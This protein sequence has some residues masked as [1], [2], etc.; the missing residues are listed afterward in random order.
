VDT[1]TQ[2]SG[3]PGLDRFYQVLRK[4]VEADERIFTVN[5]RRIRSNPHWLRDHIHEMKGY[6]Y[7]QPDLTSMVEHLLALQQPR[8]FFYE[9]IVPPYD[10]HLS[11]VTPE[12]ARLDRENRLGYVRLE[13][14][15]D[16]E[17]LMV[18]AVH[19]IWQAGGD[20]AW[21]SK[22]LDA[23]ARGLA[24]DFTDPTRWDAQRGLMKR[25]LTIDTWDFTYGVDTSN[26]RIEPGM[27][28]AIMH[29]DNSGL[30]QACLQMAKMCA[31]AGRA[32]EAADYERRARQIR[33][34]ANALLWNGRF[35]M[36]QYYLQPVQTGVNE[37][38]MLSLSNTYDINRGLPTQAMAVSIIDEYQ[39]RRNLRKDTHF[40]EWFT[41]DPPYPDF[42]GY[43]PGQYINGG[44]AAF[45]AG[46]LAKAAFEHGRERYGAD[47]LRRLQ[48]MVERAGTLYF[49]YT[50]DGKDQGGG[51][52]GWGAAAV[53]SAL[54]EG[55]CGVRDE[56]VL[57]REVRLAPRFPA[58]GGREARVVVRY[59]PSRGYC[60]YEYRHDATDKSVRLEVTGSGQEYRFHVLLPAGSAQ[61][62]AEVNGVPTPAALARLEESTYL[63]FAATMPAG[64]ILSVTVRYG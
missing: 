19:T 10:P 46:E 63:D 14:E 1:A 29:G 56:A 44:I 22:Q 33:E 60:A 40:A 47:I 35:Y 18:E 51:P 53:I 26:R 20:T 42:A 41:V 17:Y 2:I 32:R 28:M 36:H 6:K 23:L 5:G 52:P 50:T 3:P 62:R 25:T 16:I 24:Y 21:M 64:K 15:A 8:G 9:I 55:L 45:V 31:A 7:W 37:R 12:Y 61:A 39:R 27:A 11:F 30:Y 34:R 59:G 48:Q 57:M 38:E 58:A 49:F 13:I 4:V 43:R 54:F